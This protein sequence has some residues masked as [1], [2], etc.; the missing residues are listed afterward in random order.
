MMELKDAITAPRV[1][2]VRASPSARVIAAGVLVVDNV[3]PE[4]QRELVDNYLRRAPWQF[5][6]KSAS[7]KDDYSFWHRHFA[8]HRKS[9]S[10][11]PYDCAEE[12]LKA[13]PLMFAMWRH[14]AKT[15]FRGHTLIRCYANAQS[16]GTDGTSHKDSKS[17]TSYT[18][19]YY[20]HAAWDLDWAGETV[21]FTDDKS[22]V[23]AAIYPKPNRLA[24]F[25]GNV[26]HAARGV[27]RICPELRITLMMK[28]EANH[29][30]ARA[31]PP[32]SA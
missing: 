21:I 22:D 27:S 17:P 7:R 12:L 31:L 26:L 13:S 3:L 4:Q 15:V 10:E 29:V 5:G 24:V 1:G 25:H 14:L 28:T 18:A 32:V 23:L 6:W 2:A 11:E 8:G 16:Y 30:A 19:V 9:R 20:P